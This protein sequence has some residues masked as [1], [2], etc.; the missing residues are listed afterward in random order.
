MLSGD[1]TAFVDSP[2]RNRLMAYAREATLV[3]FVTGVGEPKRESLENL[4]I[5][6]PGGTSRIHNFLRLL[7]AARGYSRGVSVVTAQDPY[8]T[9][10]AGVWASWGRAPLNIQVHGP[11]FDSAFVSESLRHRIE[12]LVAHFVLRSASCVRVVSEKTR[13]AAARVT[14]API[15]VLPIAAETKQFEVEHPRPPEYGSAP[16]ILAVS[17]LSKEKQIHLM[18]DALVSVP[19][20]HLYIAGDGPERDALAA[21]ARV[22]GLTDRVHFLGFK[23]PIAPYMQ[24]ASVVLHTSR[25]ESYCLTLVE[26]VLARV[27]VVTTDVG[28]ARELPKE[29]VR[30]I[31]TETGALPTALKEA[32]ER[33]P[34]VEALANARDTYLRTLL[35][36]EET[37]RRFLESLKTCRI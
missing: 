28:V 4:T 15:T 9:G 34:S 27:P 7:S 6:Y 17:R 21:H 2:F 8:F 26:A 31:G 10:L 16:V 12:S 14:R 36:S 19:V 5:I 29:T 20:A 13:A 25:Y 30:I 33:P 22:R 1:R 24:H 37:S 18:L 32:L 3:V 11:L 35:T 23:N